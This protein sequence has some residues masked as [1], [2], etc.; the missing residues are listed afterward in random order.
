MEKKLF[1]VMALTAIL[2]CPVMAAMTLTMGTT[3]GG[4]PY[5]Y[6]PTGALPADWAP[7]GKIIGTPYETFCVELG[8]TFNP[9]PTY[10]ATVD[11]D[12]KVPPD[13]V[14]GYTAYTYLTTETK[15][16]Y[17]TW[18]N[19]QKGGFTAKQFQEEI[20]YYQYGKNTFSYSGHNVVNHGIYGS[21][22]LDFTGASNILVLNLW[23]KPIYEEAYDCQSVMIQVPA[24][25]AI[26]LASMGMG[27]VG[28]L[29]RR[30]AL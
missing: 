16:L 2:A 30:Q 28:W 24:P 22:G 18:L 19:N 14:S 9:G 11:P 15:S 3:G 20:W 25:G 27:F 12:V 5:I 21:S 23:S 7:Y 26:M 4:S 17:A 10:Y 29:R 1:I 6:T 8:E 13:T